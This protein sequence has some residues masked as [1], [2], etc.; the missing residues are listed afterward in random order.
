MVSTVSHPSS[1]LGVCLCH[2][3]DF[4]CLGSL[5]FLAAVLAVDQML[6]ATVCKPMLFL[7]YS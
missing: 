5:S 1:I 4:V 2:V 6:R 3:L 7:L